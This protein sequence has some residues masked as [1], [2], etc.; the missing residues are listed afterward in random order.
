VYEIHEDGTD[1]PKHVDVVKHYT[2]VSVITRIFLF[3]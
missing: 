3:H 1:V 2:D